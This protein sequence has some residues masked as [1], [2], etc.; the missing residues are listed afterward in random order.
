[1]KPLF[2]QPEIKRAL[3]VEHRRQGRCQSSQSSYEEN[4]G[5]ALTQSALT[6]T[7]R[8]DDLQ[9]HRP[10]LTPGQ[11]AFVLLA[12]VEYDLT[13]PKL[14]LKSDCLCTVFETRKNLE[15]IVRS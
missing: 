12:V 9:L 3:Q 15:E 1:M 4:Q 14:T 6:E 7:R 10:F 13:Q 2:S 5:T 11:P 8:N